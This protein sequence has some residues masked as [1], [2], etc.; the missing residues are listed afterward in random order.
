M[1]A[2]DRL[3]RATTV[4]PFVLVKLT[5]NRPLVGK[6]GARAMPSRPRSPPPTVDAAQVEE[7]FGDDAIADDA[8]AAALLDG[9]EHGRV[10]GVGDEGD[11][12]LQAAGKDGGANRRGGLEPTGRPARRTATSTATSFIGNPGQGRAPTLSF[13]QMVRWP[14]ASVLVLC[15]GGCRMRRATRRLHRLPRPRVRLRRSRAA[16]VSAGFR[17]RSTRATS[18]GC[19]SRHTSTARD[20][21][22]RD[23]PARLPETAASNVRRR[24]RR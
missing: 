17:R 24:C 22:S 7:V 19:N 1:P 21:S 8:D 23:S 6:S 13:P 20:G 16:S 15:G 12:R 18:A 5:K 10:G 14:L 11:R 9:I 3:K 2:D 4:S